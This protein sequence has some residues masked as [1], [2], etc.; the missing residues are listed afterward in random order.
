[1]DMVF[2]TIETDKVFIRHQLAHRI[3]KKLTSAVII[4]KR[5]TTKIIDRISSG[6]S[7]EE[8]KE[9]SFTESEF[10]ASVSEDSSSDSTDT[11]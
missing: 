5:S 11:G 6:D 9:N 4:I 10:V 1:M 2:R 7:Q 3:M 8:D